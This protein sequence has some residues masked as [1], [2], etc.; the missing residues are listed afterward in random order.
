MEKRKVHVKPKGDGWSVKSEGA[1]RAVKICG[2]QAEAIAIGR[3]IAANRGCELVV[4]R[5]GGTVRSRD[6]YGEDPFPPRA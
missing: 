6:S 5:A 1:K 4:H 3:R 2:T